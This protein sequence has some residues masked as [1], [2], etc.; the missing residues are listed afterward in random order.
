MDEATGDIDGRPPDCGAPPFISKGL[1]YR[2]RLPKDR[3]IV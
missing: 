1:T 3:Q 2:L